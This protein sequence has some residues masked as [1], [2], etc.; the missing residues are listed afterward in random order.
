MINFIKTKNTNRQ[1]KKAYRDSFKQK[2]N[3]ADFYSENYN[4]PSEID[5]ITVSF[6][7]PEL[8]KYQIKLM[9]KFLKG[10]YCIIICDNSTQEECSKKI[11]D[12]CKKNNVTYIRVL[13]RRRPNGYSNS[14][15]IALNW[16]WQNVVKKR[17]NNFGFLDHDIYPVREIDITDYVKTDPIYGKY[18]EVSGIWYLW[19]GFAFFNWEHV[20]NLP[21][22]FHRYKIL[23]FIKKRHVDTGSAN[24]N[25]LYKKLDITKLKPCS[26]EFIPMVT[27]SSIEVNYIGS[28]N[29]LHIF[30][31]GNKYNTNGNKVETVLKYLDTL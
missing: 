31:G 14:H 27:G 18:Y 24:W 11:R 20:K 19:A 5:L 22:N 8:I 25:C 9:K 4:K 28:R 3:I 2:Y 6:N 13:D 7:A 23:G 26:D 10:N 1:R 30:D 29:W 15:A 12:T 17:K 16:I 21:L